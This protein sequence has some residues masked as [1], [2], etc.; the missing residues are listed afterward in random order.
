M[1]ALVFLALV[2]V[3]CQ[4][5]TDP[6]TSVDSSHHH[7]GRA[8]A[9]ADTAD[10]AH[11]QSPLGPLVGRLVDGGNWIPKIGDAS[12]LG[13]PYD[14]HARYLY[15]DSTGRDT[16]FVAQIDSVAWYAAPLANDTAGSLGAR[17][18]TKDCQ[19]TPVVTV[20]NCAASSTT[21]YVGEY[22]VTVETAA[23]VM[24]QFELYV[25]PP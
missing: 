18:P 2:A 19:F 8:H 16:G 20:I 15:V 17:D 24:G 12:A 6:S 14:V 1:R 21:S 4:T 9:P 11:H 13:T 10:T 25:Y 22:L 7:K 3:A 23:H 5:A